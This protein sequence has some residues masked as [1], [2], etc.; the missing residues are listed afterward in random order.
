MASTPQ[1]R[2]TGHVLRRGGVTG[3]NQSVT[4]LENTP[5]RACLEACEKFLTIQRD[6]RLSGTPH[7]ACREACEN[8][9]PVPESSTPRWHASPGVLRGVF[10][11]ERVY[12]FRSA[13]GVPSLSSTPFI[14]SDQLRH[15]RPPTATS[16]SHRNLHQTLRHSPSA[17]HRR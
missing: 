7:Q 2:L 12:F 14:F 16:Y 5:H 13:E 10:C 11:P 8:L 15:R 3:I 4:R 1:T 6:P 17:F 9:K